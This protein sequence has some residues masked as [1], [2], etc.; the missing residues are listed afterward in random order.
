ME[1]ISL[2]SYKKIAVFN[3]TLFYKGDIALEKLIAKKHILLSK[4]LFNEFIEE[5]S[6]GTPFSIVFVSDEKIIIV[7]DIIRS[8]PV[9]YST[10]N[11][12]VFITE[13]IKTIP[14][15]SISDQAVSMFLQAGFSLGPNTIYQNINGI[16]A[17]E[18]LTIDRK[19][20]N[21]DS[22]RYFAFKPNHKA[23]DKSIEEFVEEFDSL[24]ITIIKKLTKSVPKDKNLI[25]PLSGGCDSRVIVNYLKK[26]NAKNVICFSYGRKNNTQANISQRVAEA[27][28]YEWYFVEYTEEK[29]AKL[30]NIGL[31]DNY[32][33]YSFQG[34]SIPHLQD[35][36]A[37][38]ELRQKKI[39]K[40]GDVFI[41][42]HT[43]DMLS[44]GHFKD[45]DMAV[46]DELSSLKRTSS[47]H[48]IVPTKFIKPSYIEKLRSIYNKVKMEPHSFQEYIN[49]QERQAKFIVNSCKV[50]RFFE[51]DFLLP[52]WDIKLVKY[53]LKLNEGNRLERNLFISSQRKGILIPELAAI[54]F[55]YEVNTKSAKKSIKGKV[56]NKIPPFVRSLAS[57]YFGSKTYKAEALNQI[58]AL[59]GNTIKSILGSYKMY[60][61][62]LQNYI[63]SIMIR[64]PYQVNYHNLTSLLAIKKTLDINR[65]E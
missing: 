23:K 9:F 36:L 61:K 29:W 25:I 45:I 34:V 55:E 27:C 56:V 7:S 18:I 57:R 35:F 4:D 44:G 63:K 11:N 24:M 43:L 41:P 47:R 58:Y 33:E 50:Y 26:T 17:A 31:I 5:N 13:N 21:I 39:I 51:F 53:F 62:E 37:V 20:K 65:Q 38:Y 42:G 1:N 15:K 54:E 30:H 6:I 22:N 52:F 48:S 59:Q 49:W 28:G 3:Q 40:K 14:E 19:N 64:K 60:P 46:N 2:T 10:V 8:Y 12:Q 16:Q 32:I